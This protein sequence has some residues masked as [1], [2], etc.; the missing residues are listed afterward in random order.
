MS[1][2]GG[3][4]VLLIATAAMVLASLYWLV[5][6]YVAARQGKGMYTTGPMEEPFWIVYPLTSLAF[7]AITR[8]CFQGS[9]ERNTL[10]LKSNLLA[11]ILPMVGFVLAPVLIPLV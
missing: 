2:R 10:L 3:R 5:A 7:G 6:F 11:S 4:V 8:F 1:K 9:G